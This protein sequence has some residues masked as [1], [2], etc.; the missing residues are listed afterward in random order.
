MPHRTLLVSTDFDGTI[1]GP[2][3]EG[4]RFAAPF[5]DWLVETRKRR[6]VVWT[7]NTGRDWESLRAE[8]EV[9]KP[10]VWP[11]WV[12]LIERYVYRI[13]ERKAVP[14]ASWNDACDRAH[15]QLFLQSQEVFNAIRARLAERSSIQLITDT[16]SP[17]G[18][19]TET[20]KEADRVADWIR[21]ILPD[22]SKLAVVRNSV[23]FRFCHRDFN[24]GSSLATIA[25]TLGLTPLNC[26]VA[27]DH[28]ND[29]PMLHK[30]Y[31][32]HIACPGNAISEV[33]ERVKAQGGFVAHGPA[34][35]GI[36][37]ALQYFFPTT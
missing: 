6:P 37:E 36:A 28:Y 12:V 11:D 13:E 34:D 21:L 9:R 2:P 16:G 1:A 22:E 5:F 7:I 19:I 26:F 31:A 20:E 25:Q 24:K 23:Y 3:E 18:I 14:F 4:R 15:S 27:G 33:K 30:T 17:L 32:K 10:D 29:L 35:R 8:L